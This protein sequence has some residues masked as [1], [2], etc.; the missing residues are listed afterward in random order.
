M[1]DPAFLFYPGDWMT[2]TMILNRHQKGCYIDLLIA[3]FNNGPLSLESIQTVL[4][5][6][7]ATWT[8]LSRKFKKDSSGNYSNE[9]LATEIEKR[10][11]FSKS[12]LIN[13]KK[14]GRP[15]TYIKPIGLPKNNLHLNEDKNKDD[16]EDKIEIPFSEK[17]LKIWQ[18]WKEYRNK[19]FRKKYKS[20][21]SEQ[22]S[23]SH[24]VKLANGLE[25]T[26]IEIIAESMANQ[27]QGLFEIKNKT[28]GSNSKNGKSAGGVTGEQL[29][30]AFT[31]F[32]QKQ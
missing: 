27:W 26:A 28:N 4:G 3:Q 9:R 6:D 21:Q 20:V 15:K 1:R 31:K 23:L 13:G 18:N 5:Q 30:T 25:E 10:E 16:I 29:N 12:R 17:F 2:G 19:E 24:L 22:A 11:N 7:Q 8:V 32:Y 14:G